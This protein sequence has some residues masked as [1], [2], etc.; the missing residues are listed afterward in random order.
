MLREAQLAKNRPSYH[1]ED[2]NSKLKDKSGMTFSQ[3]KKPLNTPATAKSA[4]K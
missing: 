2:K 1:V 4:N 3:T